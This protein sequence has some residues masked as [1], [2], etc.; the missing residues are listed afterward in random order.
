MVEELLIPVSSINPL[1]LNEPLER[2]ALVTSE[3]IAL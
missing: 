1:T 3:S 2:S